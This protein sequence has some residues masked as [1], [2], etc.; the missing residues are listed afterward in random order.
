M[1]KRK[2]N[3]FAH[4]FGGAVLSA[5]ILFSGTA[6]AQETAA[7]TTVFTQPFKDERALAL[8]KDMSDTLAKAQTMRFTVRSLIPFAA[9]TG[10]QISL[11]GTTRVAMQRPD[12]LFAENRGELFPHNLY[13]NG[14]TVTTIGTEKR[15]YAQQPSSASTIEALIEKAHPGSDAL[16]PFVDLLVG[17]PFARLTEGMV[18]AMLVGQSTLDAVNTDHLAFS[19]A[20]VDWEIWIGIKD[21][22]PRLM[23]VHYRGGERH[24]TFTATFS[25]WKLGA[26]IAAQTFNANI[27]KDAVKI[28]FKLPIL[29]QSK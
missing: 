9:P 15:F 24:P 26:P 18:G 22:L 5:T 29:Q 25:D 23:V 21:K 4:L 11:F 1:T 12:K 13:F 8:L 27:P 20:G 10:Q 16:A 19:G 17:D 2:P 7:A 14:T 6:V 3:P 28:D